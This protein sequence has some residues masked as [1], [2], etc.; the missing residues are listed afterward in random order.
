MN[1]LAKVDG[2]FTDLVNALTEEADDAYICDAPKS[3]D[4]LTG[5]VTRVEAVWKDFQS[6]V[7]EME[8]DA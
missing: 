5:F 8:H 3:A 4:K 7:E 2:A 6:W 1:S